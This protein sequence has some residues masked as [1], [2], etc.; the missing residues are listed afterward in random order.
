MKYILPIGTVAVAILLL[1]LW[2]AGV[3]SSP[4]TSI[5]PVVSSTPIPSPIS[6]IVTP[7]PISTLAPIITNSTTATP[8]PTATLVPVMTPSPTLVVTHGPTPIAVAGGGGGGGAPV[9]TPVPT[10]SPTPQLPANPTRDLPSTVEQGQSFDVIIEFAAPYSEF[11][12]IG[13]ADTIPGGWIVQ[14]KNISCSPVVETGRLNG[15]TVEYTWGSSYNAGTQFTAIYTVTMPADVPF[16]KY[17]FSGNLYYFI[18][19]EG[20]ITESIAGEQHIFIEE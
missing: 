11:N 7:T 9:I 17:T 4:A 5:V 18:E 16:G 10:P 19:E 1:V 3:F 6:L 13:I 12:S 20:I 14:L 15:S 2:A 8:V